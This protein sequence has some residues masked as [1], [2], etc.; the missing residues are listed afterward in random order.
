MAARASRRWIKA[1]LLDQRVETI[2]ARYKPR[3]ASVTRLEHYTALIE[4]R[5]AEF[6]RQWHAVIRE[7]RAAGYT[8]GVTQRRTFVR[9]LRTA[10]EPVIRFETEPDQQAQIDWAHCRWNSNP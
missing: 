10:P 1:G 2:Q 7:C 8:G 3:P 9:R 5:L 4:A 6:P